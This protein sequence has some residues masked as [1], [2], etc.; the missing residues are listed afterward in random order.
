[1]IA[2]KNSLQKI[3]AVCDCVKEFTSKINAVYDCVKEYN[4]FYFILYNLLFNTQR[5]KIK[6]IGM[7][8]QKTGI[9]AN[10][11]ERPNQRNRFKNKM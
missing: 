8:M 9:G 5:T 2:L 1:M 11:A 6:L 10:V 3:N 7:T 4:I